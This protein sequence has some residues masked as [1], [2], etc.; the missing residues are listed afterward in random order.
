MPPLPTA[1][2]WYLVIPLPADPDPNGLFGAAQVF[3]VHTDDMDVAAQ[4]A[5][6]QGFP[7][8]VVILGTHYEES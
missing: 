2:D 3:V 4:V 5:H 1:T 6:D 7:R 8:C